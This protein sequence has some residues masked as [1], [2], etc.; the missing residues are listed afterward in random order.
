MTKL[1]TDSAIA[2]HQ[3]WLRGFH[4]AIDGIDGDKLLDM[5]VG[6][7]GQCMLG[8][9]LDANRHEFLERADLY[10]SIKTAHVEFHQLAGKVLQHLEGGEIDAA[11]HMLDMQLTRVSDV[12]VSHLEEVRA[13]PIRP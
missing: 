9:W 7:H 5:S 12:L 1:D 11:Q 13:L 3:A 6:D 4:L 2:A 8:I 10:N